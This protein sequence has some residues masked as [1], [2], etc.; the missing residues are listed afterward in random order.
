MSAAVSIVFTGLC[1]LVAGGEGRSAQVLLAD[2]KGVGEIGGI[3][4]PEHAP[5][6]VVSLSALANA[7]TSGPSRVVTAWPGRGSAA[8]TP[9]GRA[10]GVPEQIGDLGPEG[11]G[12]PHQGARAGRKAR[13]RVLQA[14]PR[15]VLVA[16]AAP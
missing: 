2:A 4:L 13:R 7:E 8:A 10:F 5:T 16:G 11:N 12:D 1:A 9:P 3:A 14:S 6:L 15:P